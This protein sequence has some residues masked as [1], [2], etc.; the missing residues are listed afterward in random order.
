[1]SERGVFAIDR[2]IWDHPEFESDAPFGEREAWFWLISSAAWKPHEVRVGNMAV[3]LER[4]QLAFSLRFMARK[5][6]WSEPRVRRFL[7]RLENAT[8]LTPKIDA[9]Y[10][11]QVVDLVNGSPI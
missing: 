7:R 11:M 4:G 5:W 8:M 10:W 9:A 3:S 1:M 2:R 6:R